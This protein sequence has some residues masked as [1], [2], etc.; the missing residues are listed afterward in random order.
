MRTPIF[1]VQL[2][3]ETLYDGAV[4]DASVNMDFLSKALNNTKRLNEMVDDLISISKLEAGMKMSKRYFGINNFLEEIIEEIKYLSDKKNINIIFSSDVSEKTQVFA[5]SE[6]IKQVMVNLI[7][8]AVKYTSE[9]GEVKISVASKDKEVI[10]SIEDNGIGIPKE[11]IPRIFERFYRVE[12][13]RSRDKGGSGL[14]LSIVKHI[15][16]LH[17]SQIKIESEVDKGTKFEFSLPR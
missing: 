12:K 8:N 4:N 9:N 10:I 2:S 13:A 11:D 1:A 6:K 3:L 17:N 15:L 7:D 16:E 14:G 5:D